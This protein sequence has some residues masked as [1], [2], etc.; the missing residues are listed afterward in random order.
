MNQ[1][2]DFHDENAFDSLFAAAP[3]SR[4][5]IFLMSE[6]M[7]RYMLMIYLLLR[8]DFTMSKKMEMKFIKF[9]HK[10]KI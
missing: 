5:F 1:K 3:S 8:L 4:S 9:L 6:L 7:E 2:I 10:M